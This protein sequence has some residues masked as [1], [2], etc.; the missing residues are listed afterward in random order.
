MEHIC[1]NWIRN[2]A[3]R[4]LNMCRMEHSENEEHFIIYTAVLPSYALNKVICISHLREM[5]P[6]NCNY[7]QKCP[8]SFKLYAF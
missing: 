7:I 6:A 8:N 1:H 3:G 4:K 5:I 2:R